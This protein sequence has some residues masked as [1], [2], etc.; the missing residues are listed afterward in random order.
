MNVKAGWIASLLLLGSVVGFGQIQDKTICVKF[1]REYV[2]KE[3]SQRKSSVNTASSPVKT[4]SEALNK[5]NVKYSVHTMQPMFITDPRYVERHKDYDIDLFY[6]IHYA[7]ETDI[8]GVL[9][10]YK[11]LSCVANAERIAKANLA[12]A[13]G[14]PNLTNDPNVDLQWSLHNLQEGSSLMDIN[15]I[16]VWNNGQGIVG[17]SNLVVAIIDNCV[18]YTHEDLRDNLWVNKGEIPNNNIDDDGNGYIDDVYGWNFVSR[19]WD[20]FPNNAQENHGTHVAGIVGAR[21]NNGIGVAGVA[22]GWD[23]IPGSR[24]MVFRTGEGLDISYGYQ[25]MVYAADNGAVIAN[26]SWSGDGYEAARQAVRYFQNNAGDGVF[27]NGGILVAAAGNSNSTSLEYPACYDG[28]IAVGAITSEAARA[29][30]SNFGNWVSVCAPGVDIISTLPFNT[31]GIMGGTSMAC[32]MVSGVAALVLSAAKDYPVAHKTSQWLYNTLVNYGRN[33]TTDKQIGRLISAKNSINRIDMTVDNQPLSASAMSD[34]QVF[35]N[36]V[37]NSVYLSQPEVV[38]SVTLYDLMGVV[39]LFQ[40]Y[41]TETL[42]I[43]SLPSGIYFL[44]IETAQGIQT[45]KIVKK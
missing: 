41:P 9:A 16:D 1:T 22:G 28:V 32:P 44:T 13:V 17:D 24:I 12:L 5:M 39:R 45:K 29:S 42:N 35:P 19:S 8:N 34:V 2:E 30:F 7:T 43:A 15:T 3:L 26:C 37:I 27:L 36:P 23:S 33:I 6:I 4:H 10:D 11:N 21:T 31:Y 25:A 38:K 40:P 14:D 20:M 18:D